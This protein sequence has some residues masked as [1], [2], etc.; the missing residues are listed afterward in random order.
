MLAL[1]P[2]AARHPPCSF[3]ICTVL[4]RISA[5]CDQ[6]SQLKVPVHKFAILPSRY[7]GMKQGLRA[8][9]CSAASSSSKTC[10]CNRGCARPDL[11]GIRC[12]AIFGFTMPCEKVNPCFGLPQP[13]K[14]SFVL[15]AG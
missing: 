14:R 6:K 7:R 1:Q 9:L 5:N 8:Q 13:K 15:C 10:C 12:C 11:S 2:E 3:P 4:T